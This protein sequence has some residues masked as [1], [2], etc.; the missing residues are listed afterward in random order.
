[1]TWDSRCWGGGRLLPRLADGAFESLQLHS[2]PHGGM[3]DTLMGV[4]NDQ[5]VVA[6]TLNLN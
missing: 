6:W 2:C 5:T 4:S 1:M 3:V